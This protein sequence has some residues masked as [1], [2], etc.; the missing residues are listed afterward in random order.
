[1]FGSCYFALFACPSPV[2]CDQT[3]AKHNMYYACV[4]DLTSL[5][6]VTYSTQ[7]RDPCSGPS[8]DSR[9][10]GNASRISFNLIGKS[11]MAF[12]TGQSQRVI[13][14]WYTGDG[15]EQGFLRCFTDGPSSVCVASSKSSIIL[16]ITWVRSRSRKRKQRAKKLLKTMK[17]WATF[18]NFT[19]YLHSN[20]S[21]NEEHHY[22]QKCNIW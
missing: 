20:Y 22:N 9:I 17:I 16:R 3:S 1:M 12:L 11:T 5:P 19:S 18:S 7:R 15:P 10:M 2:R 8:A 21:I 6:L 14:S 4:T 13:K